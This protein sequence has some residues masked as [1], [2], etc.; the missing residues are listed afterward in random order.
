MQNLTIDNLEKLIKERLEDA[1]VL[2]KAGRYGG[3]FYICGYAVELG[4]KKKI[5]ITLGWDEYSTSK[6]KDL[7]TH[8]FEV[9]LHFSGVEKHIKKSLMSEWS[10]VMK[11]NSEVRYSSQAQTEEDVKLLIESTEEILKNL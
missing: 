8:D 11:W 9:L 4:L 2:F 6:C 3:A 1:K 10:I 5:C 7:K